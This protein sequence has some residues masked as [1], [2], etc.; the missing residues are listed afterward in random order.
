MAQPHPAAVPLGR[1]LKPGKGVDRYRV[2]LDPAHFAVHHCAAAASEQRADALA[3]P[4][5][6]V[7]CD[8]PTDREGD[9]WRRRGGHRKK[10][11][12]NG[13]N[14]SVQRPMSS[15][16]RRGLSLRTVQ[17][18]HGKEGADADHR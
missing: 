18:T 11:R 10:D 7:A 1:K 15:G 5:Q 9:P 12:S 13:E 4:R 16:G 6:I 3:Q 8:R 14:S 17:E 2:G